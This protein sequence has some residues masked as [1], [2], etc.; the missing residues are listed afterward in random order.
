[1]MHKRSLIVIFS[2]FVDSVFINDES[3]T[4]L[5][6]ALQHL[7]YNKHEVVLF[8]VFDKKTELNLDLENRPYTFVDLETGEQVKVNPNEVRDQ[9]SALRNKKVADVKLRCRQFGIDWVETDIEEP[10]DKVLERF[11]AKRYRMS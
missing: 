1:M 11:L 5:F 7:R 6:E 4:E 8:H 9:Y 3:Q 10:V 2:D